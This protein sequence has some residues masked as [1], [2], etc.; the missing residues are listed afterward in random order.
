[1]RNFTGDKRAEKWASALA[2]ANIPFNKLCDKDF[3]DFLETELGYKLP[4][5]SSFRNT[6]MENVVQRENS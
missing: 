6:Y 2:K 5:E 1:M 3:R 4:S